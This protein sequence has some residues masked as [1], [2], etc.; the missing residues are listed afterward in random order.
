MEGTVD[1][2]EFFKNIKS[3]C[4]W[5]AT[6][7]DLKWSIVQG[8]KLSLLFESDD[9]FPRLSLVLRVGPRHHASSALFE[10]QQSEYGILK[11]RSLVC[12]NLAV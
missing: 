7:K 12:Q 1:I 3:V 5:A 2:T 9:T 11:A 10:I 4:H 8:V 6:I